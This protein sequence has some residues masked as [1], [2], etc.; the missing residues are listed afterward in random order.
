VGQVDSERKGTPLLKLAVLGALCCALLIPVARAG[1]AT[2]SP[3]AVQAIAW[4]ASDD[5]AKFANDGG[6]AFD[7]ELQGANLTQN[8]WTV[9][10]DPSNPTAINE[11]PFL[12]RAAPV[13]QAAGVK[14][15][16]VLYSL[17]GSEHDPVEFCDWAESVVQAANQWGIHDFVVGNEVNTRLYWSP[18]KDAAGNDVAAPA[19]EALL[20]RCY[21]LI[22]AADPQANVIGM[23]L[24]PRAS[25]PESSEP[26]VFLRDVGKAY[27]AS[28]R[29]TPIMDQLSLHPYPNPSNPT[30][31][32]DVGYDN[33]DR[34]G[35][36]NLDRVKQAVYDAFNGTGQPT[37]LNGLTFLID[38]VGWQTDTSQYAGYV[39]EE[40]VKVI[41]EQQQAS[42]IKT[43]ATKYFA[44]DPTVV[45][46]EL[47]LLVDETYRN[48]RDENGTYIGG[49]WQSGLV[50]AGGE[51]KSSY[52]ASAPLFAAGRAACTAPLIS[53]S[54]S[55]AQLGSKVAKLKK[56][57]THKAKK[58]KHKPKRR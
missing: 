28:G 18:Q 38:E 46:V 30:D 39:N 36:S 9:A 43:M 58:P 2:G 32:P 15:I 22:H 40:N 1:A 5:A 31:S 12:Q 51:E 24:S 11:L 7:A 19:Y 4:G 21:D 27:R 44:C 25:T 6:S 35:I 16:L 17:K 29:T 37:T 33:P 41:S 13:A 48:G 57:A 47:F 45:G 49:G 26:L 56:K 42:F 10:F 50:T 3:G 55:K 52:A 23:G 14:V 8:R 34:F 54:P 53:W 20:A